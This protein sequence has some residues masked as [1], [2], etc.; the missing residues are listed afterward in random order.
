MAFH[1]SRG[2]RFKHLSRTIPSHLLGDAEYPGV[3]SSE[4]AQ[5]IEAF[6]NGA[7]VGNVASNF[8]ISTE[9]AQHFKAKAGAPVEGFVDIDSGGE[10]PSSSAG[11][12]PGWFSSWGRGAMN[13]FSAIPPNMIDYGVRRGAKELDKE[14]AGQARIQALLSPQQRPPRTST[15]NK[16]MLYVGGAVAVLGIFALI[17]FKK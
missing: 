8:G 3:S 12:E 2:A 1:K 13:V 11:D 9:A 16:T 6:S 10:M 5:I 15:G 14:A 17:A 4:E 7:A